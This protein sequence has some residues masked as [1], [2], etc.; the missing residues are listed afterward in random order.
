ME[1]K[2]SYVALVTP[3]KK[4]NRKNLPMAS[5]PRGFREFLEGCNKQPDF[6]NKRLLKHY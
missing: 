2:G 3:F 6:L 1:F 5:C 4:N